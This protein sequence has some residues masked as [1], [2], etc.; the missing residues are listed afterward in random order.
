M[1]AFDLG[2]HRHTKSKEEK[3]ESGRE[4][5]SLEILDNDLEIL[6]KLYID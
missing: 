3:T 4:L 1:A 2:D 5:A 6:M